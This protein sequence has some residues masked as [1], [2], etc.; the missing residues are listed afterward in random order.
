M[1]PV[2]GA[3]VV[4]VIEDLFILLSVSLFSQLVIYAKYS[5]VSQQSEVTDK[6]F[7]CFSVHT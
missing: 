6:V 5:V 4:G 1:A 3:C 7:V 2:S